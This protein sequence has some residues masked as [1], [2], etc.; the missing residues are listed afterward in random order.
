VADRDGPWQPSLVEVRGSVVLVTGAS[1]GIGRAAAS[2]FARRGALVKATG[3]DETALKELAETAPGVTW[4]AADLSDPG[5]PDEVAS[6]AGDLDVLV[7]N[8]GLG[9][10]GSFTTMPE[11][12]IDELV[13]VNLRAPIRLTRAVLPRMLERGRGRVVNV[14]S[15]ASHVPVRGESVYAATKWGLAG[16]GDSLRS[17]LAGTGIGVTL[18]SPGVV[19][20]RFFERRGAPYRRSSPQPVSAARVASAIARAVQR[21]QD[22][23]FVPGWL[24]FPARLRGAWPWLYR[25]LAARFE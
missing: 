25:R 21:E 22:D 23:V 9:F 11:A 1:S 6:W 15:I 2:L 19:R 10:E 24:A 12:R 7:N 16:F 13:A 3:R 14:G 17:E 20:T 8:A 5:G 4:L 18:V